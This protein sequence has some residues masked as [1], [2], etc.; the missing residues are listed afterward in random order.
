MK[1]CRYAV[2]R[3]F[4]NEK[5]LRELKGSPGAL[6]ERIE[7]VCKEGPRSVAHGNDVHQRRFMDGDYFFDN[8][9]LYEA[10]FVA[11]H[12][13]RESVAACGIEIPAQFLDNEFVP[14]IVCIVNNVPVKVFLNPLDSGELPFDMLHY[15]KI[16]GQPWGVGV[17]FIVR[18]PQRVIRAAWRMIMENAA[19]NVGGQLI[20]NRSI[21]T[22]ANGSWKMTGAK[23]WY[24]TSE[25]GMPSSPR[26]QDAFGF[27]N[28][29]SRIDHLLRII[30]FAL[31]FAEDETSLPALLE[32]RRGN[33][34]DTV[35]GMRLLDSRANEV[36]M[37]I[38][39]Q[40]DDDCIKPH[41]SRYYEWNMLYSQDDSIKGDM[42]IVPLGAAA[43]N[44]R[45]IEADTLYQIGSFVQSPQFARYHKRAGYDW[46]RRVY[47]L[48]RLD[49]DEVLET[50]DRV[51][52]IIQQ[53]AENQP[54]DP[55]L[56][57]ARIAA[58]IRLQELR[59]KLEDSERQRLHERD[60][61]TLRFR[62]EMIKLAE[63]MAA[64]KSITIEEARAELARLIIKETNANQRQ[65]AEMALKLSPA[66]PTKQGI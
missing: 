41:I 17:P 36:L 30:E 49:P 61:E 46:L 13:P 35:G 43:L 21:V 31:K 14:A 26:V 58:E 51:D 4:Y 47:K 38:I 20:V 62:T 45:T 15:E 23:V 60:K 19:Q 29:E 1:N 64:E 44:S 9:L 56:E 39:R 48:L 3:R 63:E 53:A 27:F 7:A 6:D 57:A 2:W 59:A 54:Q 32:G 11:A 25:K 34:P 66:N 65:A 24:L 10:Y 40:V 42:S 50:P 5:T 52:E 28:P 16:D 55:R 37:R 8:T 12:F 22:P 33:A 18:N